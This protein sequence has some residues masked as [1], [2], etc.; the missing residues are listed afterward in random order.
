MGDVAFSLTVLHF[1]FSH[2]RQPVGPPY[3][4]HLLD[5]SNGLEAEIPAQICERQERAESGPPNPLGKICKL[6]NW[7]M[8]TLAV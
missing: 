7:P 3:S 8:M 4:R 6:R 5:V 2:F 1:A